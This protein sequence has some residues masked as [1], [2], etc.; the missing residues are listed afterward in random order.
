M[1]APALLACKG[2]RKNVIQH[3]TGLKINS[4]FSI[5]KS[6]QKTEKKERFATAFSLARKAC[7]VL[8][9]RENT[10]GCTP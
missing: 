9:S 1:P 8:D 7:E 3:P 5:S 4:G 6:L 2:M 10:A